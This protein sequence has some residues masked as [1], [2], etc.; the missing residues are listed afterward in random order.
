MLPTFVALFL[1]GN[2]VSFYIAILILTAMKKFLLV[3]LVLACTQAV[4]AQSRVSEIS[5]KNGFFGWQFKKGEEKLKPGQVAELLTVN[6]EASALFSSG[7]S[8]YT[9]SSIIGAVGGFMVGYTLGT[10]LASGEANWTVGGIGAGLIVVSIPI[11]VN[12]TSNVRKAIVLY[13]EGLKTGFLRRP[14]LRLG[15]TGNGLGFVYRF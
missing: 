6:P 2:A 3:F 10:S 9:L 12:A 5:F 4:F 7:R 11:S 15:F 8:G 13:N 14:E 1:A